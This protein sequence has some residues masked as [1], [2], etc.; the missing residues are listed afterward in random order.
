MA[1]DDAEQA[2]IRKW[3]MQYK[4]YKSEF[5]RLKKEYALM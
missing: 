1:D 5:M 4:H 3:K 2:E